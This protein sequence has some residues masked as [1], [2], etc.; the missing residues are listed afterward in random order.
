MAHRKWR[1]A[2]LPQS[3]NE[4]KRGRIA[5]QC[6]LLFGGVE[7]KRAVL[8]NDEVEQIQFRKHAPQIGKI[9][10]GYADE[11]APGAPHLLQRVYGLGV[12]QAIPGQ[13]AVEICCQATK[14][15]GGQLTRFA[16]PAT[17]ESYRLGIGT[18]AGTS[19]MPGRRPCPSAR[20]SRDHHGRCNRIEPG[21]GKL[22]EGSHLPLQ[23]NEGA[24]KFS[25]PLPFIAYALKGVRVSPVRRGRLSGPIRERLFRCGVAQREYEVEKLRVA[26][27]EFTPVFG[28]QT[29]SRV[30][31]LLQDLERYRI[32]TC[33]GFDPGAEAGKTAV[34]MTVDHG[35][36]HKAPG[37]VTP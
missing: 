12:D 18:A 25:P 15:M 26:F 37:R 21:E 3:R 6:I 20:F 35:L 24:A 28:S 34:A 14:N 22:H 30:A 33:C 11:L 2:E 29:V 13:S 1:D 17:M 36:G 19:A 10:A 5:K 23:R 27:R 8:R 16:R 31:A 9:P 7:E 4:G 32:D